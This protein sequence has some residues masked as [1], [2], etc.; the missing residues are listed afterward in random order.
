MPKWYMD[1][2][3]GRCYN[4]NLLIA[5]NMEILIKSSAWEC[6]VCLVA[7]GR[8]CAFPNCPS[9]HEFCVECTKGLIF[10]VPN[11]KCNPDEDDSESEYPYCGSTDKCPLCR[12]KVNPSERWNSKRQRTDNNDIQ[13]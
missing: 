13:I 11:P 10:G 12:H 3:G 5:H 2:H 8:S 6:P 4:C 9:K 7:K 1:C